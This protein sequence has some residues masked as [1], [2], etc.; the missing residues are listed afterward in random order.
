CSALSLA[1]ACCC[2][3]QF[4]PTIE[5]PAGRVHRDTRQEIK[6]TGQGVGGEEYCALELPGQLEVLDGPYRSWFNPGFEGA[7]GNYKLGRQFGKWKECNRFG[8]CEQNDYPDFDSS[9]KKRPGVKA[10]IPIIYRSGKYVFDFTS[11]RRT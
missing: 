7:A 8:H 5:C 1:A 6:D 9:E 2:Y 10:E 11:C 4:A 3:A